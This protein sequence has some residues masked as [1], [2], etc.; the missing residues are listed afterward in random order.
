ML[1]TLFG[2]HVGATDSTAAAAAPISAVV[3]AAL[4]FAVSKV[5]EETVGRVAGERP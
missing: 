1:L 4:A 2:L 5:L 3:A